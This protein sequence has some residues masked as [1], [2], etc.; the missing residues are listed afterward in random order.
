MS[1]RFRLTGTLGDSRDA[2]LP[3][4]YLWLDGDER[5]NALVLVGVNIGV[6]YGDPL[7]AFGAEVCAAPGSVLYR[8]LTPFYELRN[9]RVRRAA[10]F[11]ARATKAATASHGNQRDTPR[12]RKGPD[13]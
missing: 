5:E 3:R 12:T 1:R 2:I 10:P 9:R 11:D 13:Q 7:C 8:A 6:K 4:P